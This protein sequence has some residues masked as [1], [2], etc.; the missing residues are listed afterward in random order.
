MRISIDLKKLLASV[1]TVLLIFCA[2]FF[3]ISTPLFG[4]QHDERKKIVVLF[5]FRPTLPIAAQWDRGLRSIFDADQSHDYLINIEHLDLTHFGDEKHLDLLKN[6]YRYKYADHKPDL[7]IPVLGAAIDLVLDQKADLFNGV[8]IVFG[9]VEKQFLENLALPDNA[10][11]HLTDINYTKTLELALRLHP[12]TRNIVI[13]G[14]AGN[15][16]KNWVTSSR[17]AYQSYEDRFD[18]TYLIG[19]PMQ[20]LLSEVTSL[21]PQTIIISLPVLRD[22]NG[23][24]FIAN[25]VLK[26]IAETANA[27]VYTFWDICLGTGVVGGHV[28]SF[29]KEAQ[30]VA[31]LGLRV[32]NG[33]NP[34]DIPITQAPK[35][36]NIFDWQQ[37]KR[38]G[39][40][41]ARLPEDSVVIN[42]ELNVFE[43]H[44]EEVV[45][46]LLLLGLQFLAILYLVH[47]RRIRYKAELELSEKRSEADQLQ[48][49][50][51]HMGRVVTVS[52]LTAAL[53]HEINQPLA[54]MRSY[55]QAALRFMDADESP[56][57]K[58]RTALQG[59]VSD[60]K[61][62]ADIINRLRDLVK[63]QEPHR[64]LLDINLIINDVLSLLNSE[65]VLRNASIQ[66]NLCSNLPEVHA[67]TVQIQQV[68]LNLLINALDAVSCH[69]VE[70]RGVVITTRLEETSLVV[71]IWDSGD[72]VPIEALQ[73]VFEPFNTTKQGGMGL[74][75]AICKSIVEAHDG[76]IWAAC[77][78]AGGAVFSFS[79]PGSRKR[80]SACYEP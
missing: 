41:E 78:D 49:E 62:A 61:R 22:G 36:E 35:Y 25:E 18:I 77:A 58:V 59:I 66:V 79:L 3:L 56:N 4:A 64:E 26:L 48:T 70:L 51:T 17:K 75:L 16:V 23:Q 57:E 21:P 31:Q 13:V 63:K 80:R 47:Q 7:I 45:V 43:Q 42:R 38:W 1:V 27:P 30:A 50:L 2:M 12:N 6:L 9:G 76:T 40:P 24:E 34:S 71:S 15:V 72:G 33:E 37:L 65:V 68:V 53:A 19:L 69:P 52:T 8:P 11:G 46:I 67:D 54:A 44:T 20:E 29:E 73:T 74:G 10:T 14:G 5:S 60:N 39:I 55:A 28:G 32:L